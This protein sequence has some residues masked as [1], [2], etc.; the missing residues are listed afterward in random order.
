MRNLWGLGLVF[1][2]CSVCGEVNCRP[3]LHV[4]LIFLC[5]IWNWC[6]RVGGKRPII[7]TKN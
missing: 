3:S 7:P 4:K 1:E 6:F 5:F 2:P